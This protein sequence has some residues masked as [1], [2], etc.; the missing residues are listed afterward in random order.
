MTKQ[1][2]IPKVVQSLAGGGSANAIQGR[3]DLG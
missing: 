3:Y 1:P 2:V